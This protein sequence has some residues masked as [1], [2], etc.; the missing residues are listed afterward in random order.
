MDI[1]EP[2][3]LFDAGIRA[4][5]DV[6]FEELPDRLPRQLVYCRF[7]LND[8]SGELMAKKRTY[9]SLVADVLSVAANYWDDFSIELANR[10]RGC[11]CDRLRIISDLPESFAHIHEEVRA[12]MTG[13][14]P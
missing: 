7:P 9:H 4:V 12:T 11:I 1:R 6:A 10:F 14:F 2:R 13:Q 5:V 8:G 3:P